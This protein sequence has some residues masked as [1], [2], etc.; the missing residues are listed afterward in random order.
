[1]QYPRPLHLKPS[2]LKGPQHPVSWLPNTHFLVQHPMC[3]LLE[4][5]HTLWTSGRPPTHDLQVQTASFGSV[6]VRVAGPQGAAPL[7]IW[8]GMGGKLHRHCS[9]QKRTALSACLPG[10][11]TWAGVVPSHVSSAATASTLAAVA[12]SIHCCVPHGVPPWQAVTA[13]PLGVSSQL[14]PL[15]CL[16]F[17]RRW[18]SLG[19]SGST[20]PTSPLKA[21]GL[22]SWAVPLLA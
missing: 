4:Q 9:M 3:H 17:T 10:Q 16:P 5:I 12:C 19:A 11:P 21:G 15:L 1:M 8:H 22:C 2:I 14:P 6:Q 20:A 13:S 7:V 18:W